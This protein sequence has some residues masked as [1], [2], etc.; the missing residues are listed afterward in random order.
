MFCVEAP[1]INV[2]DDGL[3]DT[4][5]IDGGGKLIAPWDKTTWLTFLVDDTYSREFVLSNAK[6]GC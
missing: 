6:C 1:A 2:T 3:T 4:M 5:A